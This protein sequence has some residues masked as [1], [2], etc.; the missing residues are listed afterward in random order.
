MDQELP[1]QR[2][3]CHLLL[4]SE[5]LGGRSSCSLNSPS[6]RLAEHITEERFSKIMADFNRHKQQDSCGYQGSSST[7]S[8]KKTK[9]ATED[10]QEA[11]STLLGRPPNDPKIILLCKKVRKTFL[12]D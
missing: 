8:L 3:K 1:S 12:T 5:G 11:L 2:P 6:L 4:A 7:L 10:F 9:M